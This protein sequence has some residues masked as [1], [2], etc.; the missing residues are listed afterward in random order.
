MLT[1]VLQAIFSTIFKKLQIHRKILREG[2]EKSM[3]HSEAAEK[4]QGNPL[5]ATEEGKRKTNKTKA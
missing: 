4:T 1:L 2:T 3:G 5:R